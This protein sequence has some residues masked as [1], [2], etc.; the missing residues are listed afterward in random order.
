MKKEIEIPEGKILVKVDEET[1][2]VIDENRVLPKT[3]EEYC[4]KHPIQ[5]GEAY[6]SDGE[7]KVVESKDSEGVRRDSEFES[8]LLASKEQAESVLAFIKLL[9]DCYNEAIEHQWC[10]EAVYIVWN[11]VT[12]CV[13]ISK[14]TSTYHRVMAFKTKDLAQKFLDNF[15]DLLELAKELI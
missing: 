3:W 7:A 10:G 14:A 1:Y 2:K 4:E 11:K 8:D 5:L 12:H 13:E 6:I 9:R 15:R